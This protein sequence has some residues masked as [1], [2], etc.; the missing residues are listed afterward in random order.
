MNTQEASY[1]DAPEPASGPIELDFA[2]TDDLL[3][4]LARRNDLVVV[5]LAN[6]DTRTRSWNADNV[7]KGEFF[8]LFGALKTMETTIASKIDEMRRGEEEADG[9]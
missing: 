7:L 4:E 3:E 1:E 2:S 9:G 6:Y 8:Q 5:Y